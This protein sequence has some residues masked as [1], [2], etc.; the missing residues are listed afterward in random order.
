M[1]DPDAETD[2]D[3]DLRDRL[4]E[5]AGRAEGLLRR[6]GA[7]YV[8]LVAL[9][10]VVGLVVAPVA[11]PVAVPWEEGTVAI[12][13]LEGGI[14]G[15]SAAATVAT[16]ERARQDPDIDA[17]VLLMNSPGGGAAASETLYLEAA[18][19]AEGMP[20]VT[21]VDAL[22]ASG[23]YYTAVG[24]DRI[25]V[26]PASLVGSVGV[27]FVPPPQLEPTDAIITT[28]PNK[29]SGADERGW[30]YKTEA[31]KRA[32]VGAVVAG[33]GDALE[34]PRSRVA[35]AEVFTGAE[36]VENG[37]ADEIGGVRDA[38]EYAARQAGLSNYDV[39]VLR[40][41]ESPEFLT[42]AG[43]LASSAPNKTMTS[44][45]RFVGDVRRARF[46]NFLYLPPSF[47]R[48]AVTAEVAEVS[49]ETDATE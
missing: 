14:D 19:A 12:I 6:A 22:A 39:T 38:V 42:R 9:A 30:H 36:A 37:M 3:A 34:A 43:Y 15:A 16:L 46:P 5:T 24:T 31:L 29:L 45:D 47:A 35:T 13:P 21:S 25:F 11:A 4:E 27:L 40:P 2:G 7:S 48:E 8:V 41:D 28:G 49:N 23:A 10:V 18:K 33:R 17:V 26:K 20:V 44:M 1:A 32:F